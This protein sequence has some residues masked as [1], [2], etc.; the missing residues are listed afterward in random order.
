MGVEEAEYALCRESR[1]PF[2]PLISLVSNRGFQHFQPQGGSMEIE[3]CTHAHK[4]HSYSKSVHSQI[5]VEPDSSPHH[6]NNL[7]FQGPTGPSAHPQASPTRTD[8]VLYT[9]IFGRKGYRKSRTGRITQPFP[10]NFAPPS[11]ASHSS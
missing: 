4:I 1:A 10:Q 5:E 3:E 8:V 9:V 11:A 2:M 7:E 6:A